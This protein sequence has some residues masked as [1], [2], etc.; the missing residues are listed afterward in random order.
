MIAVSLVLVAV[1]LAAGPWLR[2]PRARSG[3]LVL[4][5]AR[6]AASDAA[7]SVPWSRPFGRFRSLAGAP[8]APAGERAELLA[9]ALDAVSRSLRSGRSLPHAL[10]DS[11]DGP[12]G[13]LGRRVLAGAPSAPATA[14]L[15]ARAPAG[16]DLQLAAAAVSVAVEVGGDQARALDLAASS[17]RDRAAQRA[18]RHAQSATARLSALVVG[19]LPLVVSAWLLS[20]DAH[21]RAFLLT[22]SIGLACAAISALLQLVAWLW[23]RRL[24]RG[25]P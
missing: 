7:A 25:V 14:G 6:L 17:L 18:E 15:L 13:H 8:T 16:S 19:C 22:S 10:A 12:L 2:R 23:I 1:L 11:G 24:V 5:P 4:A 3:D 21:A 20:S 9:G